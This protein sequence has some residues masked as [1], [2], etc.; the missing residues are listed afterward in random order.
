[1][2]VGGEVSGSKDQLPD[3]SHSGGGGR[4]R[5][6]GLVALVLWGLAL[7]CSLL[8]AMW[9]FDRIRILVLTGGL[10]MIDLAGAVL[11]STCWYI[12]RRVVEPMTDYRIAMRY[13]YEGGY[14]DG[15]S[16][17]VAAPDL[18]PVVPLVP[19]QPGRL[20]SA[21]GSRGRVNGHTG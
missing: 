6:Y 10:M 7:T 12:G 11:F 17:G 15:Y 3:E 16:D 21:N 13:G 4:C 1:M 9:A 14:A 19:H 8:D 2:S 18:S 20:T 5:L